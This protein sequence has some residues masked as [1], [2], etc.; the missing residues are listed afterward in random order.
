MTKHVPPKF[1]TKKFHCPYCQVYAM[2]QWHDVFAQGRQLCNF[3]KL[4]QCAHCNGL[5]VWLSSTETLLHPP[6]L[7]M[8]PHPDMPEDCVALYHEAQTIT[9]DSPRAAAALLRL[10]LQKFMAH[11]GESE[12]A[13]INDSIASLVK[14]GLAEEVQQALDFCRV[15][16]NN[17]VHPGEISFDD[18]PDVATHLFEVVNFLVEEFIAKKKRLQTLY[19]KLPQSAQ[20]SIAKRDGKTTP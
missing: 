20:A 3:V 9:N 13:S 8:P 12:K 14:K 2:Q 19:A 16:G 1:D 10:L 7:S 6:L 5:C 4:S 18:N 15:V 11:C 17:A